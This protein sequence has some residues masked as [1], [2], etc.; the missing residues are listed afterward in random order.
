MLH[1]LNKIGE[2]I[3]KK[4]IDIK[5]SKIGIGFEKLDRDLFDP[6]KAYPFLANIGV[7]KVRLQSGWQRTEK[8]KGVYDFEWLDSIVD[9]MLELGIEPWLCLCYGNKLYTEEAGKH[10]GA[11]GCPP[12]RTEEERRA[13][14]AYVTETVKH[15]KGRIKLYEVWNEPDGQWCWKHGPN[16]KELGEFTKATA[17]ACKKA[18]PDCMVAGLAL[19]WN[20]EFAKGFFETDAVNYLDAITYHSYDSHDH[21][22]DARFNAIKECLGA[23]GRQDIRII[24][25][26]AG[27]QSR[28]DGSGALASGAWTEAIQAK[29]LLRHL[30]KDIALGVEFTS[31][32]S[33]MDMAEALNGTEGELATIKDFGYFGVVGA[34]F[35]DNARA[36]GNYYAKPSYYALQT[37]CS[38]LAEEYKLSEAEISSFEVYSGRMMHGT[39]DFSKAQHYVFR[40]EDGS[41]ALFYWNAVNLLTETYNGET[42]F[43]FSAKN[44]DGKVCI[45]DMLDGSIYDCNDRYEVKDGKYI[46]TKIPLTDSPLL[47]T[48]GDFIK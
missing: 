18:D 20:H 8:E 12:I 2:I 6:E 25:G 40:R 1:F 14:D 19:C 41:T 38:V 39:F 48:I 29:Y 30:I 10:F 16:A 23:V 11:V 5:T 45:V 46:F 34:E 33:T 27:T 21:V 24:Q 9:K 22:W 4:S 35:D 26:E 44:L 7:K 47:I 37:L 43:V 3:P 42:S 36:T 28:S 32:F 15:F 17:K 31:Y 13:W